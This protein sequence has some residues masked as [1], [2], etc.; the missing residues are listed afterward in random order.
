MQVKRVL[1]SHV[2]IGQVRHGG[3]YYEGHHG[4]IISQ[5]VWQETQRR[6]RERSRVH[7]RAVAATLSP[8]FVCGS[9]GSG[10]R[11]DSTSKPAYICADREMLLS[12]RRSRLHRRVPSS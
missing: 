11:L 9:C 12:L 6:L 2:Y 8:L 7:G 3:D 5:H 4:A 10:S 1:A